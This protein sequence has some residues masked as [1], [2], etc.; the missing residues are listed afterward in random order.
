[1]W[2]PKR[3]TVF[4]IILLLVYTV[5]IIVMGHFSAPRSWTGWFL[6]AI[7]ITGWFC[8]MAWIISLCLGADRNE[9]NTGRLDN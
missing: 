7:G 1:M 9:R 4:A 5:P 3:S 6:R 2:Q 8:L